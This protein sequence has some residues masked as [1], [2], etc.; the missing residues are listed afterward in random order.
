M[1]LSLQELIRD[2]EALTYI[3]SLKVTLTEIKEE[4]SQMDDLRDYQNQ[5]AE[6]V[7]KLVR[8]ADNQYRIIAKL[9][10]KEPSFAGELTIE[11]DP[12]TFDEVEKVMTGG[13]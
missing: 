9:A 4:L 7:K 1:A 3:N 8:K 11:D 5:S 10:Q 6:R 12:E 2:T 13:E